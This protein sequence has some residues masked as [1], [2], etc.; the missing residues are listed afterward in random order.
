MVSLDITPMAAAAL[1]NQDDEM[2]VSLGTPEGYQ[3]ALQ[4]QL[5]ELLEQSIQQTLAE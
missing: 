5:M 3:L 1:F 4:L 2:I